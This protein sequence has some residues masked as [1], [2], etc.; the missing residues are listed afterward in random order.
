MEDKINL[1]RENNSLIDYY[2]AIK[3]LINIFE[4]GDAGVIKEFERK[5]F[6]AL[7]DVLGHG[8]EARQLAVTVQE[9]LEKNYN[10][11]PV[12]I[13]KVLDEHIKGSRGLVI[14]IGLLDLETN[15]LKYAGMGNISLKICD[16]SSR[17]FKH[18]ISKDGIVGYT[19]STPRQETVKFSEKE[20]IVVYTDGIKEHFGL[21][22]CSKLLDKD[23]KTIATQII[24]KFSRKTDDAACIVLKYKNIK[25]MS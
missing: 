25:E 20:V 16:S 19:I 2:L 14:G 18:I 21:E 17:N 13:I 5:I 11:E 23:A 10:R 6:F 15:L 4:C 12:E 9:F 8:S 3:P 22:G 24:Q 7:I 1:K